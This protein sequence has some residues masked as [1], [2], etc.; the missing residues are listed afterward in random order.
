MNWIRAIAAVL[1]WWA[2]AAS[3]A[4]LTWDANSE[5]DLAGYRVYQCSQLPC[6][7][8]SSHESLLVTLGAVT[9]YNIGAPTVTQYYF[10]T[11]Y[12]SANNESTESNLATFTPPVTPP[13][14]SPPAIGA[15]PISFYF[16]AVEGSANPATQILNI[17]NTGGG[18]L[19]WDVSDNTAWLTL[20]ST[21]G[22]GNGAVTLSVATGTL[23]VGSYSGTVTINATGASSVTVPV[24]F[25]ITTP[26]S[27]KKTP[28]STPRGLRLGKIK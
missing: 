24:V 20:S 26:G 23:M 14:V 11:A 28:P 8:A 16:T 25:D 2:S 22:T 15:N 18:T 21:F 27:T 9:S 12:D 3:G 5:P 4:T 13:P 7:Q 6:T 17:S 1:V 19:N 10:I